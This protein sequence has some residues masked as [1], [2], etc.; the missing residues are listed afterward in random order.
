MRH[1][2]RL[3]P[4]AVAPVLL[5]GA[6]IGSRY[7]SLCIEELPETPWRAELLA[8]IATMHETERAG[9]GLILTGKPGRGKTASISILLREAMARGPVKTY[10]AMGIEIDTVYRDRSLLAVSGAPIW[11]RLLTSQFVA[12]DDLGSDHE[13]A[14]KLPSVEL[15]FRSRANN[16]LVT[17]VSTNLA[18][19]ALYGKFAWLRSL[20][21]ESFTVIQLEGR[22]L[23]G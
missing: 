5:A 21:K 17:Y 15:L 6:N 19:D 13:T 8:Y 10:F 16:N 4:R 2:L 20:A 18:A 23:R 1:N 9:R 22:D 14:W 12:I 7:W 3:P 11:E